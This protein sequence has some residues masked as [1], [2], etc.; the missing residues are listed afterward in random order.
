[1]ESQ[2]SSTLGGNCDMDVNECKS[3]PC[4]NGGIC[5]DSTVD[6]KISV[7]AYSCKCTQ[8]GF[9]NGMC[10]YPYI[11]EYTT[12]C[13][14]RESTSVPQYAPATCKEAAAVSVPADADACAKVNAD[15]ILLRTA[16]ACMAVP[17]ATMGDPPATRACAY[18][19]RN[20]STI[21]SGNCDLDVNECLSAPCKG[22]SRCADST[23]NP[24]MK[25][26]QYSCTCAPGYANGICEFDYLI[27]Y[28]PQCTVAFPT[29]LAN[30]N[31]DVD[32]NECASLP[33]DH[34]G[35]CFDSGTRQSVAADSYTCDCN[36]F[37][38]VWRGLPNALPRVPPYPIGKF[39]SDQAGLKSAWTRETDCQLR[40]FEE[41]RCEPGQEP[42]LNQT[43][44]RRG[45]VACRPHFYSPLGSRCIEC[46]AP[47]VIIPE[48][49]W[50]RRITSP[51]G[52]TVQ[53]AQPCVRNLACT[54]CSQGEV[55]NQNRTGCIDAMAAVGND[56]ALAS[57]GTKV[58]AAVAQGSVQVKVKAS[59]WNS[60]P[61]KEAFIKTLVAQLA[62]TMEIAPDAIIVKGLIKDSRRRQR[63]LQAP[64]S[65]A[66]P[67]VTAK[68]DFTLRPGTGSSAIFNLEKTLKDPRATSTQ[69]LTALGVV[70]K[71]FGVDSKCPEG[72]MKAEADT[73]CHNCPFP[74]FTIDSKTCN[75]C[76]KS[77]GE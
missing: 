55:P 21:L 53:Q 60:P 3:S 63:R 71:S 50:C 43:T 42:T 26:T 33:C 27:R 20:T 66:A 59:V 10:S 39:L 19:V 13:T 14:V 51:R 72:K 2:Q 17:T 67:E 25:P 45:C 65:A 1:M 69:K 54:R 35:R 18:T 5:T 9:A 62:K 23:T 75:D 28:T 58:A 31:C 36:S 37:Q 38:R 7:H 41:I 61:A 44:R 52:V 73:L 70:A 77:T 24:S 15:P 56:A 57:L 34:E 46:R 4:K 47:D 8:P 29:S 64:P 6:P 40:T 12:E 68:L 16:S 76:P 30:G 32:I 48:P 49:W 22:H 74:Q 11:R